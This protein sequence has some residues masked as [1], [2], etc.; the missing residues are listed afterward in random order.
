MEF[1]LGEH[2]VGEVYIIKQIKTIRFTYTCTTMISSHK[3][4]IEVTAWAKAVYNVRKVL[5]YADLFG[6]CL[7][8]FWNSYFRY[9][10][11]VTGIIFDILTWIHG[12][13]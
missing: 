13:V 8:V 10:G 9:I 1:Y 7:V 2:V 3:R 12:V 6:M 11:V 5:L 4:Y